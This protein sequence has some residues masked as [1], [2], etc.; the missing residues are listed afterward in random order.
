[1]VV[2]ARCG[3]DAAVPRDP[4]RVLAAW[5]C[6]M[7]SAC[8]DGP[9]SPGD[10]A[11]DPSSSSGAVDDESTG[12]PADDDCDADVGPTVVR[13]LTRFEYDNSVRDLLGTDLRVA[14]GFAEEEELNGFDNNGAVRTVGEL[15][16]EQYMLA[17]ETLA[18]EAVADPTA[19]LACDITLVGE[20]AC[21]DAFVRTFARR[22][23]RRPLVDEDV[24]A[25]LA[26]FAA[27]RAEGL[28]S[29]NDLLL[30]LCEAMDVPTTTIGDP[31]F[32]HGPL[33][34]LRA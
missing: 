14:E 22:A 1:M 13:R 30:S 25:L 4:T 10:G 3:D 7:L 15:Q 19:L 21:V 32:C 26:V 31:A 18:A 20:D 2:A 6:A 24:D 9:D 16:A 17:A 34:E 27:G 29:H 23:Y 5:L 11:W 8:G 12:A 33:A 28:G